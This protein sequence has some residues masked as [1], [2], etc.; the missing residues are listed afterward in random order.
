MLCF[1]WASWMFDFFVT[2]A[3]EIQMKRMCWWSSHRLLSFIE[4]Q[5]LVG[6]GVLIIEASLSNS[7]TPH[8]TGLIWTSD[9][10]DAVT[11][12]WHHTALR[13]NI[14]APG[15]IQTRNLSKRAT[16]DPHLKAWFLRT[17]RWR[18]RKRDAARRNQS[19]GIEGDWF[20]RVTLMSVPPWHC[21]DAAASCVNACVNSC[22]NARLLGPA[23]IS[24]T[25]Q[26]YFTGRWNPLFVVS[27]WVSDGQKW[28][29][30]GARIMSA[31]NVLRE[32]TRDNRTS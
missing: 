5:P 1:V 24:Y 19:C 6:Q 23:H 32:T 4:E 26:N 29:W 9:R 15:G 14:H 2:L 22:V 8:S 28:E 18:L 3:I 13:I 12:T 17:T 11:A 16:A 30:H 25:L 27:E 31:I 7:D 21:V 10:S 20:L